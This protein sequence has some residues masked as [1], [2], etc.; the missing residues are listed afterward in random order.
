MFGGGKDFD[1]FDGMRGEHDDVAGDVHVNGNGFALLAEIDGAFETRG[2]RGRR[3]N[4]DGAI[5][6]VGDVQP[7]VYRADGH[8]HRPVEPRLRVIVIDAEWVVGR[9]TTRIVPT[10]G[11]GVHVKLQLKLVWWLL[12]GK[13]RFGNRSGTREA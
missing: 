3:V 1:G 12:S 7:T 11:G 9:A 4:F 8:A 13:S 5:F 10:F 6:A 2:G